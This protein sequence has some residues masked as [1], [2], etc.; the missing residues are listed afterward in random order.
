[1]TKSFVLGLVLGIIMGGVI[2]LFN[3]RYTISA[4]GQYQAYKLDRWTGEIWFCT[5]NGCRSL[6]NK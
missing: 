3:G 1:M 5:Q 2:I 6:P 4:T